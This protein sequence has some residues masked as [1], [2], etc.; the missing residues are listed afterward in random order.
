MCGGGGVWGGYG[1][2]CGWVGGGGGVAVVT[3]FLGSSA[4]LSSLH[5]M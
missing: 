2:G 1:C 5:V 4:G 3:K